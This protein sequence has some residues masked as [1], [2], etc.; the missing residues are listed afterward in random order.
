[1][2]F[3]AY[4]FRV[5]LRDD[6]IRQALAF[7]EKE[8]FQAD[9]DEVWGDILGGINFSE[10][11][12]VKD[13]DHWLKADQVHLSYRLLPLIIQNRFEISSVRLVRPEARWLLPEEKP[14]EEKEPFDLDFSLDLAGFHIRNGRVELAD[15]LALEG[16]QLD[17]SL[18]IRPHH[19]SGRVRRSGV[20]VNLN[21]EDRLRIRSAKTGFAYIP[22]DTIRFEDLLVVTVDSRIKGD[23]SLEG[24]NLGLDLDRTVIDLAEIDPEGLKGRLLAEGWI[25]SDSSGYRGECSLEAEDFVSGDLRFAELKMEL[26]G[27][28]GVF[29][30]SFDASDPRMGRLASAGVISIT[31]EEV[32]GNLDVRELRLSEATGFPLEFKGTVDG[33]YNLKVKEAKGILKV[34]T[35]ELLPQTGL[36]LA[37]KGTIEGGY[38]S[39]S[40]HIWGD[41]N[42]EQL[43]IRKIPAYPVSFKGSV[44]ADYDLANNSGHITGL[45]DRIRLRNFKWGSCDFDVAFHNQDITL[46]SFRLSHGLSQVQAKGEFSPEAV[47]GELE[48]HTFQ[49]ASLGEYNPLGEPAEVNAELKFAG[50]GKSPRISG[51]ILVNSD[52][53]FFKELQVE[54]DSFYPLSLAGL[55]RIDVNG[56]RLSEG[57]EFGLSADIRDSSLKVS[58]S[59]GKDIFLSMIGVLNLDF[60]R[61]LYEY[62]CDKLELMVGTEKIENRLPFVVTSSGDSLALGPTIFY[63]GEGSFAATGSWGGVG[64]PHVGI[65]LYDVEL[66]IIAR[67]LGV[68]EGVSGYVS[69]QIVSRDD[70]GKRSV[71]LQIEAVDVYA[72][73]AEADSIYLA[74]ELDA[75]QFDFEALLVHGEGESKANGNV[76][77]DF[78]ETS[79]IQRFNINLT[80]DDI[81]VWPFA[82][83]DLEQTVVFR[84]GSVNGNLNAF[85]TLTEPD[86][87]GQIY[88]R[89][90]ELFLPILDMTSYSTDIDLL[91]S[92]GLAIIDK[93]SGRVGQGRIK[94]NGDLSLFSEGHPFFF[95]FKFDTVPYNPERHLKAICDGTISL[96]GSDDSPLYV[97]GN[98]DIIKADIGW[99]LT[100]EIWVTSPNVP[101]DSSLPP[102][103]V[104][105]H[106]KGDKNIWIK[107]TMMDVEVA[108]D[109]EIVQRDEIIPQITGD[110][111]VKRGNIYYGISVLK[112][113]KGE[114]FFPPAQQDLNPE[115]DIW[116]RKRTD[117]Q[118][119]SG[120]RIEA[121]L[122]VVGTLRKPDFKAF[123]DPPGLSETDVLTY[124][125]I[126]YFPSLT[127]QTIPIGLSSIPLESILSREAAEWLQDATG[128]D[129]IMIEDIG[130]TESPTKVTIGKYLGDKWYASYTLPLSRPAGDTTY[131]QFK[132]EYTLGEINIPLG[133]DSLSDTLD[134]NQDI[135]LD[136]NRYGAQGLHYRLR[137][138]Y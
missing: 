104:D 107:N 59:D 42:I 5:P 44:E 92:N 33:G 7:L 129:V 69:G 82:L 22:P 43:E 34:E 57:T 1:M 6:I 99:G 80:L 30:V 61:S 24:S 74:G 3:T 78:K 58:A 117:Y 64:L 16:L 126:G 32:L 38:A 49:L 66:P 71:L 134:L 91:F 125:S 135:I 40:E 68:E 79:V 131:H 12:V 120:E 100:D 65:T 25:G 132:V 110:L 53:A 76:Y 15:T 85:G 133:E 98:V 81:G 84:K 62:S 128:A 93:A 103:Y 101:V 121:V 95:S 87:R 35:L 45:V 14:D 86:I 123:S 21:G 23:F 28:E 50:T 102:T 116:A 112:L 77:Y 119:A 29:D 96:R 124:L 52:E 118:A 9:Y 130:L 108:A 109:L 72:L 73:G 136:R 20:L 19:V 8:G 114:I 88:I 17:L 41:M 51:L 31:E 37:F 90:A 67:L 138:R 127:G 83:L 56:L 2:L 113:E 39:G 48:I 94:G 26:S 137:L 111:N 97:S 75:L 122:R 11:S 63:I 105:I 70:G 47:E 89:D 10:L 60:N 55:A 115:L 27:E 18:K 54:F 13:D 36:P 106:V 4:F 46:K